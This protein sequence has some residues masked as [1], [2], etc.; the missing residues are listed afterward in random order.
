M[1][2]LGLGGLGLAAP[3]P[4]RRDT[5]AQSIVEAIM[6]GSTSCTG[7][8]AECRTATQATPYLITAFAQ[9][10]CTS[11][12]QIAAGLA[13]I[14]LESVELQYKHNVSPGRPGQGTANMMM[15]NVSTFPLLNPLSPNPGTPDCPAKLN[16]E[17]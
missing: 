4:V 6:P 13:W 7:K 2:A 11:P 16:C 8:L 5:T 12:A 15:A 3:A 10:G 1:A 14:A 17:N 9:W